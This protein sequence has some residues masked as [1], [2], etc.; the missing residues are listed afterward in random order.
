MSEKFDRREF[1]RLAGLAGLAMGLPAVHMGRPKGL[2]AEGSPNIIVLVFDSL[3]ASHLSFNGY[4]RETTPYLNEFIEGATVYHRHFASAPY[5]T[6]ATA[7]LLTG[8]QAWTHRAFKLGQETNAYFSENNLFSQFQAAGYHTVAYTHNPMAE[9][10]LT[11][12]RAGIHDHKRLK[13]LFLTEVPELVNLAERD[14]NTALQAFMRSLQNDSPN[15]SLIAGQVLKNFDNLKNRELAEWEAIFPNGLPSLVAN[16]ASFVLEDA[17]DWIGAELPLLETPYV[18]YFHLWPPHYPYHTRGE[19]HRA[20][21]DDDYR[22]PRKP[23]HPI[24]DEWSYNDLLKLRTDYDE[25]LLYVDAEIHRLMQTLEAQGSLENTWFVLTSDHGEL[26]ER[27]FWGHKN[28]SMNQP[29]INIPLIVKAPGQTVR[30]DVFANTSAIDVLPTLLHIAGQDA[31]GWVEGA[32]LPPLDAGGFDAGR[33]LFSFN[34]I[35]SD[36]DTTLDTAIVTVVQGRWKLI[37]TYGLKEQA[38]EEMFN[39]YD[40][41]DDPEELVDLYGV[42]D[43]VFA[44]LFGVLSAKLD[45]VG[46]RE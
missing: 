19:F 7:S 4:A 13:E 2:A 38:G 14:F 36:R 6:P 18:G 5:T 45:E 33:S 40:L 17:M 26:F 29:V 27:G 30:Q 22:P 43:A 9:I 10:L 15:N 20:F 3:S 1:L 21:R 24:T 46:G 25:Y 44:R 28:P 16:N 37:Y 8:T 31:P 39:L 34:P 35:R 42:E 32:V 11:S 23:E 41:E 12:M